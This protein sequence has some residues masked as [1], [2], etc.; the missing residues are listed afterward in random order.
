[1]KIG[2]KVRFLND[3]GGGKIT[4]FR[5]GGI[6][7]VEDEDGFAVPMPQHEVVVIEE[8][9]TKVEKKPASP[10]MM[11]GAQ[12][13]QPEPATERNEK[14]KK[15]ESQS[16][17]GKEYLQSKTVVPAEEDEVDEQ[18]EARVTHLEMTIQKLEARIA[19]LEAENNLRKNERMMPHKVKSQP[20]KKPDT[21]K[22]IGDLQIL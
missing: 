12:S 18:L 7:L 8:D 13:G 1:M 16:L 9:T 3:V 5:Q 14:S 20:K 11:A 19:L 15:G 2:D 22:T 17:N 21:P 10:K 6:V 4:G